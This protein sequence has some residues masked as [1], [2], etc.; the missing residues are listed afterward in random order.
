MN[1]NGHGVA[2]GDEGLRRTCPTRVLPGP[3][4]ITH[5]ISVEVCGKR[6][7]ELFHKCWTCA[8]AN[9]KAPENVAALSNGTTNGVAALANGIAARNGVVGRN[10]AGASHGVLARNGVVVRNGV[11]A[12]STIGAAAANGAARPTRA[13]SA[14]ASA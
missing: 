5:Q 11:V 7:R 1:A 6:Q 3:P 8:C 14:A 13:G 9:R 12:P 2:E 10:G 4:L